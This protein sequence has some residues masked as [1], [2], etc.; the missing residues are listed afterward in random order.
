MVMWT[1][2]LS[3]W[4]TVAAAMI[5]ISVIAAAGCDMT[6][7]NIEKTVKESGTTEDQVDKVMQDFK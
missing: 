4:H 3:S 6:P 2:G 1:A 7:K 5:A